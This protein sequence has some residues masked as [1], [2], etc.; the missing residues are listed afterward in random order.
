MNNNIKDSCYGNGNIVEELLNGRNK[1]DVM[2]FEGGRIGSTGPT[3]YRD[4]YLVTF[5]DCTS[6]EGI[7]VA[8]GE[9]LPID[10]EELDISSGSYFTNP[11]VTILIEY[12]GRQGA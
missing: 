2:K 3:L 8:A 12:K 5:N 4:V 10:R 9:R 1:P 6:A 7:S 11:I